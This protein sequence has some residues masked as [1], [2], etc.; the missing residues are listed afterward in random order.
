MEIHRYI[1]EFG[2]TE[3]MIAQKKPASIEAGLM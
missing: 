1:R 3:Q 2:V